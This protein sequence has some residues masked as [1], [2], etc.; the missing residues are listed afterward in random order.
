MVYA[1]PHPE[2]V[3]YLVHNNSFQKGHI[4]LSLILDAL[5]SDSSDALDEH[6]LERLDAGSIFDGA[7]SI[8]VLIF[9]E[10]SRSISIVY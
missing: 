4:L 5:I 8:N 6:L 3:A 2:S 1:V 9:K 7:Q 10:L